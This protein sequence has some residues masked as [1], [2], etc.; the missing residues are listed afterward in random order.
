MKKMLFLQPFIKI[1]LMLFCLTDRMRAKW[2]GEQGEVLKD[3]LVWLQPV[4]Q[5]LKILQTVFVQTEI[6]KTFFSS[7]LC[8]G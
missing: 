5:K 7:E 6:K 3:E 2:V 8:R 4:Q 1:F